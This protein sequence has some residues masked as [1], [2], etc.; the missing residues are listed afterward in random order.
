MKRFSAGTSSEPS[1]RISEGFLCLCFKVLPPQAFPKLQRRTFLN[2]SSAATKAIHEKLS[3]HCKKVHH[4][5][6]FLKGYLATN[7][8]A[9]IDF[10]SKK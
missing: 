7:L 4:W 8:R 5:V 2:R 3:I 10:E 1:G 9:V 6:S